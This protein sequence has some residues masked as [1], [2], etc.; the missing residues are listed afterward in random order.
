VDGRVSL[1]MHEEAIL[2]SKEACFGSLEARLHFSPGATPRGGSSPCSSRLESNH[3]TITHVT[4]THVT[5][6][7][8]ITVV[9]YITGGPNPSS[10][11]SANYLRRSRSNN[12]I[13]VFETPI[14]PADFPP[15]LSLKNAQI[16]IRSN[17]A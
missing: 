12:S 5:N 1:S 15:S 6:P 3:V 14:F 4:I 9:V 10:L 8:H 17:C 2:A 7:L 11:G 16:V 13:R